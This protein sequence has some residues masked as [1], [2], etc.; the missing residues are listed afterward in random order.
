VKPVFGPGYAVK[1][2]K[3]R[4]KTMMNPISPEL[5]EWVNYGLEPPAEPRLDS[6]QSQS[7]ASWRRDS[8]I[9]QKQPLFRS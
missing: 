1:W 7:S 6:N 2:A 9:R 5:P 4:A 3:E 8:Q